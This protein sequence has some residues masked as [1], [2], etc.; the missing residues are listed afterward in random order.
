MFKVLTAIELE[1]ID[2]VDAIDVIDK[3]VNNVN[4]FK[5]VNGVNRSMASPKKLLKKLSPPNGES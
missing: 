4:T 3:L 2:Q 1:N 5:L